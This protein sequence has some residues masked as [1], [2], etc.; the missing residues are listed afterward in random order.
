MR[1][2]KVPITSKPPINSKALASIE[3]INLNTAPIMAP[4]NS[5]IASNMD[6][7]K[8]TLIQ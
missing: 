6:T 5:N 1:Q 7:F 2:M 8:L 3:K 4:K